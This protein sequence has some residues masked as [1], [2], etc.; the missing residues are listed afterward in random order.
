MHGSVVH[1]LVPGHVPHSPCRVPAELL[2]DPFD[3]V[4]CP[5]RDWA[6]G[7]GLVQGAASLLVASDSVVHEFVRHFYSLQLLDDGPMAFSTLVEL[8][9]CISE[10]F[11]RHHD[12]DGGKFCLCFSSSEV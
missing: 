7:V 1:G 3:A 11:H 12:D 8:D 10:G 6:A 9:Y 2:P 4:H 5:D